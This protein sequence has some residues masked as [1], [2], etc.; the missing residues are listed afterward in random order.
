M[1]VNNLGL[2]AAKAA[3]SGECDEWL[4]SLNIYLTG[5]RDFLV[6]YVKQELKGIKVTMPE[7]TYLAWLDCNELVRTG[8]IQGNPYDFFL[9][10]AK[11]ALND[12]VEFGL[13]GEGFVRLNFGCPRKTLI[14]ALER[15]KAALI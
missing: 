8:R 12:G 14:E 4:Q 9:K 7:A 11:V 10:K 3:F 6:E 2:A 1:H 13:G 15:M 5:N